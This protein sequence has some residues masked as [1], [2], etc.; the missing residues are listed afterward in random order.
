MKRLLLALIL[1]VPPATSE[2]RPGHR[3]PEGSYHSVREREIDIEDYAADLRF[4]MEREE[5]TGTATL[6]FTPLRSGLKEFSLDASDLEIQKVASGAGSASFSLR[7]RELHISL[8]QALNP[9][10][11]GSVSITY[12][13]HPKT[14]MYFYPKSGTRAAQAWNY[15]EGGLHYGWLPIYNDV[16][17]RFTVKFTITVAR[18]FVAVSNGKLVETKENPDGTRTFRW[19][20]EKPIPNYLMTVDVG[21]FAQVPIGKARL[22][23]GAISLAA[24]T[25]PGTESAAAFS[26]KNTPRMVEFFSE[27]FSYPY[28]WFKY[29][30]VA[31][32]EF[33]IGAMETTTATGFSESHL[34]GPE[35]PPD[36]GPAYTEPYPTWSY[37]DTIAHELA[38]HWFGDLVTCR[39]LASIWLNESFATFSHTLWNGHAHGEDDLT[40]QRWRYLNKYL[41]YVQSTGMV[42]PMEYFKY[43]SPDDMYQTETT[44]LKGSLVLHMLR[45]FIGDA[46]F[47]RTFE[48][49]LHRNEYGNVDSADLK[50]A[51]QTQ[52]GRNLSWFFDDWITEGGGHPVFQVS[53]AWV[54]E[55]RQVDLTV[56]QVQADLPFENDFSLPVEVEILG[57]SGSSVHKVELKGW[58]TRAS[59]P[60]DT[61]PR[62]VVFDKGNWLI[63][64]I[65]FERSADETVYLLE[66]ADLAA[67]LRAARQLAEDYP[68]RP[69][70]VRTLA[71][72]LGDA[73]NHWGLRQEA[74]MDLGRAGGAEAGK[75][76]VLASTDPDRRVRR[77]VA[78]ALGFVAD[79]E[80]AAALRKLIETDRAE[81][82]AAAAEISLG[83]MRGEGAKDFLLRQLSRDSRY[84]SSIRLGALLGLTYL[85]DPSLVPAFRSYTDS[86]WEADLRSAALDGWLAAA[87]EDPEL[88]R[89]LRELARDRN[90]QGRLDAIEKLGSLHLSADVK[91]LS[92][93]AEAD[94]D[95]DISEKARA[96][97]EE[98]QSFPKK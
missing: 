72:V 94:P 55:R 22:G 54:P 95:P 27:R 12:S 93:L 52:I 38:H 41:D 68:R 76:L 49:Y 47:F 50:E 67:R 3:L 83:R 9:G 81:D 75:A 30:Q 92:D 28:P 20:Q 45:H 21:E 7:D 5:I 36:S 31:L 4:D 11:P 51:F 35:D 56:Q 43:R 1:L 53:Y 32:R 57:P 2:I 82:V 16:N 86:R 65:K 34:H 44:Y 14:G 90:R 40:Y 78:I 64:E 79:G 8:T 69:E 60:A 73:R 80:S 37:E 29:H 59:L 84:W 63:C 6:T 23:S 62:A 26:F 15:G 77:A 97:A 25:P 71:R 61:R 88:A 17:D 13:C 89:R 39:S 74:A 19:E 10:Q 85:K 96:A 66:K 87:P 70:T 33:A 48:G 91:F 42:R 58:S 24:W 98:I 46:D 18:P